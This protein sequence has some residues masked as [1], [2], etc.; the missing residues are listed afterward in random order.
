MQQHLYYVHRIV[1]PSCWKILS[2]ESKV[3]SPK[4]SIQCPQF[5]VQSPTESKV[6]SQNFKSQNQDRLNRIYW[7]L[8]VLLYFYSSLTHSG[9]DSGAA[10]HLG[11]PLLRPHSRHHGP[12]QVRPQERHHRPPVYRRRPHCRQHHRGQVR[13]VLWL[14]PCDLSVSPWS[15][16]FF[17]PFLGDFY[18]TWGPVRTRAWTWTRARQ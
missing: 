3:L 7:P 15:K 6:L 14:I 4:S 13:L 5:V 16:S 1:C 17:F 9:T 8:L 11:D 10:S 2:A 12:L 18:S